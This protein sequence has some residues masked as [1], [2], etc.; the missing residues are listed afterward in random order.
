VT[1]TLTTHAPDVFT[2]KGEISVL[3]PDAPDFRRCPTSRILNEGDVI[4]VRTQYDREEYVITMGVGRTVVS[5]TGGSLGADTT[6][7][8]T[9]EGTIPFGETQCAHKDLAFRQGERTRIRFHSHNRNLLIVEP[10][11]HVFINDEPVF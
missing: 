10:P 2:R 4:R 1:S 3:L 11:L 7:S 8:A 6:S 9:I 5:I